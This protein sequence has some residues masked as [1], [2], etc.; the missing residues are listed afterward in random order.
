MS[1]LVYRYLLLKIYRQEKGLTFGQLPARA[2]GT[3]GHSL[4]L[5]PRG[6]VPPILSPV[7]C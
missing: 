7:S 5:S 4:V 2:L 3:P 6:L 1:T